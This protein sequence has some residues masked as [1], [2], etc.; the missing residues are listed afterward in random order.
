[1]RA[2]F[3]LAVALALLVA[4]A[5]IVGVGLFAPHVS[6]QYRAFFIDHTITDWVREP[7]PGLSRSE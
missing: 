7:L 2:L 3:F 4:Q 1:M 5:C 6:A